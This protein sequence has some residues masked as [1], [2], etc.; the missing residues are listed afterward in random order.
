MKALIRDIASKFWK[1]LQDNFTS[2]KL[3]SDKLKKCYSHHSGEI[4]RVI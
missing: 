1:K 3:F 2:K 4:V